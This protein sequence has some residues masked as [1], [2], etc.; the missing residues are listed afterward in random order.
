MSRDRLA[1]GALA[2]PQAAYSLSL[3]RLTREPALMVL[4]LNHGGAFPDGVTETGRPWRLVSS[5]S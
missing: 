4:W 5:V 3:L 1:R 2:A